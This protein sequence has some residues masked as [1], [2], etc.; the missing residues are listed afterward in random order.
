[1]WLQSDVKLTVLP[2]EA[3][4]RFL[5]RPH[6]VMEGERKKGAFQLDV[7]FLTSSL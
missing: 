7:W 1:M 3:V 5:P 4:S 6:V 2:A